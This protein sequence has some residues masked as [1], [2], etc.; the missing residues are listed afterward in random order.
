MAERAIF[1]LNNDALMRYLTQNRVAL[2][3]LLFVALQRNVV[4]HW[5]PAVL[6]MTQNYLKLFEEIDGRLFEQ[7]RQ[8]LEG[9]TNQQ[10]CDRQRRQLQWE[11]LTADTVGGSSNSANNSSIETGH[12]SS[13]ASGNATSAMNTGGQSNGGSAGIQS[14]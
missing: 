9:M 4:T 13:L 6:L 14:L 2:F 3:P 1:L 11:Q 5:N 8:S 12:R 7:C 10:A